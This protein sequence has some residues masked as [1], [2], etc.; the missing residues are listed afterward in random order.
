MGPET[1]PQAAVPGSLPDEERDETGEGHNHVAPRRLDGP[2]IDEVRP[3]LPPDRE[4]H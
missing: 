1:D 3:P 4:H 2:V